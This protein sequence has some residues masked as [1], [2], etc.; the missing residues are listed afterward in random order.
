MN[1]SRLGWKFVLWKSYY[2]Q[3]AYKDQLGITHDGYV[4]TDEI[5]VTVI[6]ERHDVPSMWGPEANNDGWIARADE[7]GR[8]YYCN[9]EIY[10]D[11]S[12]TPAYFWDTKVEGAEF[13]Q[14][15]DAVQAYNSKHIPHVRP[16][17]SRAVPAG[18]EICPKHD[19]AWYIR[20]GLVSGEQCFKC[21]CDAI[22]IKHLKETENERKS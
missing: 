10:P 9:W 8:E 21:M 18:V 20:K 14:P 16:D 3:D 1:I 2:Q 5:V 6:E 12:M 11:D 22:S 7:G 4:V 19:Y 13:W 15:E 17:G